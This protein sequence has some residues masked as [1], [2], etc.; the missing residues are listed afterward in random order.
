MEWLM[1]ALDK[2]VET[3]LIAHAEDGHM[4]AE[5]LQRI[6]KEW[7]F[8]RRP[9]NCRA[10]RLLQEWQ[11]IAETLGSL[12]PMTGADHAV[13]RA[14]SRIRLVV[15]RTTPPS[16]ESAAASPDESDPVPPPPDGEPKDE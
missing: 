9:L 6:L 11:K 14:R 3:L 1:D 12:P 15:D 2:M 13:Q 4:I 8:M 5:R 10:A 7:Q 16:D